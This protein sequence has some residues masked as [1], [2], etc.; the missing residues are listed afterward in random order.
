MLENYALGYDPHGS[1]KEGMVSPRTEDEI[2]WGSD[3]L[4]G[5]RIQ[6]NTTWASVVSYR[7]TARKR[8]K[9]EQILWGLY[10]DIY[11]I[12]SV[13]NVIILQKP[14]IRSRRLNEPKFGIDRTE[15]AYK[16]I[17]FKHL[18]DKSVQKDTLWC[19]FL[20]LLHNKNLSVLLGQ[21]TLQSYDK[22][23]NSADLLQFSVGLAYSLD[24]RKFNHWFC[25]LIVDF[26]IVPFTIELPLE[27]YGIM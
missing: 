19:E 27:I 24:I 2:V 22:S 21:S 10:A 14:G 17:L 20:Q 3:I 8:T 26:K 11:G 6:R 12:G 13:S 16:T 9:K 15:N 4:R 1:W 5:Y 7:S 23:F 18:S 25:F